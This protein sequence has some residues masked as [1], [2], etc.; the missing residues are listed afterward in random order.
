M[1]YKRFGKN[2][3]KVSE[4]G[5]GTYYDPIWI[6]TAYLGWR[7][8][9][10][11]KIDAIRAG[12]SGGITLIDTAEVYG[13]EPLVAEAIKGFRREDLFIATK[14]WLN[15]LRREKVF[16]SLKNSLKRLQTGYVDLYQIHFPNSAVPIVETMGAM[17]ELVDQGKIRYIGVSNF[18]LKQTVEANSALK[19]YELASVQLNYSLFDRS[20]EADILPYCEKQ[21]I[22]VLAYFPLAHGK[23]AFERKELAELIHKYSKTAAQIALNWLCSKQNVFPIPRASNPLH[24]KENL[25]A[26]GWEISE[27]D[28]AGLQRLFGQRPN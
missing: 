2:G 25:G 9:A 13:S 5:M 28:S 10:R 15:H 7:R 4:I 23:L 18:S 6:A 11:Q 27:E 17:E 20:I 21:G 1:R 14:V 22:A 26:S 3:P 8:K 16:K 24:V 19:K 12:L